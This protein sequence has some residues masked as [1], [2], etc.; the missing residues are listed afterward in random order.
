[1]SAAWNALEEYSKFRNSVWF[2]FLVP[3]PTTEVTE[4][5]LENDF[6]G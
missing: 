6:E 3:E 1:V 5:R 2:K 4:Y